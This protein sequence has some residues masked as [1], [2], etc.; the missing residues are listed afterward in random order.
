MCSSS[1]QGK[2][3]PT[4]GRRHFTLRRASCICCVLAAALLCCCGRD[5]TPR[6]AHDLPRPGQPLGCSAADLASPARD[7]QSGLATYYADSLSGERTASGERYDPH[8]LTA[9][10][11]TLPFGTRLR[12]TRT[13]VSAPVLCV[14]VNDRGPFSG[15]DRVLDLS[16]RGAEALQ[17]IRAGVVP[18][19]IEIL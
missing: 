19:R 4:P 13:D 6:A 14:S 2:V 18:V 11:R 8:R 10:H 16:R 1:R 3:D 12:V 15:R 7:V 17:M 9:A 5:A